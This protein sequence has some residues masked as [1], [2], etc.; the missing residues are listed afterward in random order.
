M[1]NK[2]YITPKV[3]RIYAFIVISDATAT[4]DKT[5]FNGV[6]RTNGELHAMSLAN[7]Q[8]E[9][10]QVVNTEYILGLL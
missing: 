10:A 7:L 1:G 2:N 9:Y 8:G 6:M 5:D 3:V 4:F